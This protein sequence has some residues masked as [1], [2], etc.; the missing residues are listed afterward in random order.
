MS[1]VLLCSCCQLDDIIWLWCKEVHFLTDGVWMG[2]HV[3]FM[4][5]PGNPDL[6]SV[7]TV[8]VW[9]KRKEAGKGGYDPV[10]RM[11]TKLQKT[12]LKSLY[13]PG[14]HHA[15]CKQSLSLVLTV[16]TRNGCKPC[17]PQ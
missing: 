13:R 16:I 17:L 3:K 15:V 4:A 6:R 2:V 14:H 7:C 11:G 8:T 1:L 5:M 9:M 10:F 12:T